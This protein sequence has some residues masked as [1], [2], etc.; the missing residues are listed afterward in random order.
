[1]ISTE[2]K[3]LAQRLCES[4]SIDLY[5]IHAELRLSPVQL[6]KALYNLG[7]LGIVRVRG[8]RAYRSTSFFPALFVFRHL[9]FNHGRP[10]AS[11][12]RRPTFG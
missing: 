5:E 10:W 7:I 4:S 11:A 9:I 8:T 3:I 1:M 2:E 12:Q 6:S